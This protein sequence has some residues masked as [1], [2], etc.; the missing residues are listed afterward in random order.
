MNYKE[1]TGTVTQLR[2][3][4]A[5]VRIDAGAAA[6]C[7]GCGCK[8]SKAASGARVIEVQRNDLQ[9][10]DRVKIKVPQRSGYLGMLMIFVLPMIFCVSGMLVGL[11]FEA[12]PGDTNLMPLAGGAGGLGLAFGIAWVVE[13]IVSSKAPLQVQPLARSSV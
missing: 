3:K 10:G 6:G 13:R 2:G 9:K 8:C 4:K 12:G 1:E 5:V 7:S 11:Q